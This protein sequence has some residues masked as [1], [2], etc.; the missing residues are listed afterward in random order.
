MKLCKFILMAALL[1][2]VSATSAM[3]V[4][5]KEQKALM[6]Q[7]ISVME[8]GEKAVNSE[9]PT[10]LLDDMAASLYCIEILSKTDEQYS[11]DIACANK[12][13]GEARWLLGNCFIP[14]G[15]VE[16]LLRKKGYDIDRLW[17]YLYWAEK[18]MQSIQPRYDIMV[19]YCEKQLQRRREAM[20]KTMPEG[21]L[22]R[23]EYREHG[24]TSIK[25]V[26]I[27][28]TRDESG[29]WLLDG[30]EVNQ[31]VADRV[32][33]MAEQSKL[34]QCL[35]LYEDQPAFE[36]APHKMGGAPSWS[37]LCEFEGGTIY[38]ESESMLAPE[39]CMEIVRYLSIVGHP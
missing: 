16:E 31:E 6:Q 17:K 15:K 25:E 1:A 23:F 30:E 13:I 36:R 10:F 4:S 18:L 26:F 37:F 28:L 11:E 3:A 21:G 27:T 32:R 33:Q 7:A 5:K 35:S 12:V 24:S 29:R 2:I 38:S 9:V 14:E 22:V 34:Y 8:R 19:S 20:E 39:N